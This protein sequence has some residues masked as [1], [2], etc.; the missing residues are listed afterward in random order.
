MGPKKG[1]AVK[2]EDE[3]EIAARKKEA[4]IKSNAV[5]KSKNEIEAKNSRINNFKILNQWRKVMRLAKAESLKKDIEIL[6]QNHERDVDRKDAILQMIDRDLEEA[7][8]QYQMTLR[9]HLVNMDTLI[10]LHDSRLYALERG[11]EHELRSVQA[12]FQRE[13]EHILE[14]F[15][16]E[17]KDLTA[18]IECIDK[19][20]SEREAE[21]K[22]AFETLREEL[23]NRNLEDINM[24]RISLDAQ[25]EELEQHF[26][27]AHLNYLQQT[28]QRTHEFKALTQTDQILTRD[29]ESR[30][31][32]IDNLQNTIKQWRAKI[33]QLSRETEERNRLLLE[34]KHSIQTHY[35]QLKQRIHT[36]RGTQNQ[37]LLQLSESANKC[38]MK[39]NEKLD[40]A[41]RVLQL[42]EFCRKLETIQETVLPFDTVLNGNEG[43]ASSSVAEREAQLNQDENSLLEK[44]SEV[45]NKQDPASANMTLPPAY[46]STVWNEESNQYVPPSERLAKFYRI[47]N[48]VLLDNIAIDKERTR[49]QE[50]NSQLEDLVSQYVDGLGLNQQV[51]NE[52]NPLFVVNGRANLNHVPPVRKAMHPTVQDA[53]QI[54]NT[55]IRQH[56]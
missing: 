2:K 53:A 24:L 23:R 29:I 33:R 49:L 39:L 25:I 12:G 42:S 8:D 15:N 10:Q 37:R 3:A 13:K 56:V 36:Y 26:E 11:F 9:S 28:A 31:K 41:R 1:G 5:L 27:T 35:Q 19:D 40:L 22:H 55:N 4:Q 17:K 6:S 44:P 51:L 32:K 47:Y 16:S 52:D 50:E 46:Q 14:K 34:E 30:T 48:K 18:L 21:A 43:N 38:K 7:E 45:E 54:T 20:E